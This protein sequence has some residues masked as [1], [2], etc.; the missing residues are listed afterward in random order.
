M[1]AQKALNNV[2]VREGV[3]QDKVLANPIWANVDRSYNSK[4]EYIKMIEMTLLDRVRGC[5]VLV[6]N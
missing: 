3:L 4:I 6:F 1:L 5:V 2:F